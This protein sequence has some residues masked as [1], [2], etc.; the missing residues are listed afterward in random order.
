LQQPLAVMELAHPRYFGTIAAARLPQHDCR[1]TIAA[2]RLPK[3]ECRNS[4]AE[5]CRTE[6]AARQ[7]PLRRRAPSTSAV[8]ESARRK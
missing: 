1:N 5:M 4:I 3:L 6:S 2:T 8:R 7:P